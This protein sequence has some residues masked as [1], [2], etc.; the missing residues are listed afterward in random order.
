MNHTNDE[1]MQQ[2]ICQTLSHRL[3]DG[4]TANSFATAIV[5]L[6]H[7]ISER[8]EPVIGTRGFNVLFERSIQIA[9]KTFPWLALTDANN[10]IGVSLAGLKEMLETQEVAVASN[11]SYAVLVSF[12]SSSFRSLTRAGSMNRFVLSI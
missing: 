12:I 8:L 2:A 9:G 11:A 1:L 4:A 5:D 3:G 6:W 10:A 7:Q